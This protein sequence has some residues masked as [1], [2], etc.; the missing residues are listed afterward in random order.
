MSSLLEIL[1]GHFGHVDSSESAEFANESEKGLTTDVIVQYT[2][3][4]HSLKHLKENLPIHPDDPTF[5]QQFP[6][7]PNDD[8]VPCTSKQNFSHKE[9]I[10]K[11]AEAA[12]QFFEEEQDLKVS[13]TSLPCSKT[14]GLKFP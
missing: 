3:E 9:E 10:R 14:E 12:K 1:Q 7:I 2:W 5:S 6:G 11:W 4:H 8:A 13:H